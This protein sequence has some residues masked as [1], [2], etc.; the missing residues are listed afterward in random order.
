MVGM[1][2]KLTVYSLLNLSIR[3]DMRET[4]GVETL[5]RSSQ[6]FPSDGRPPWVASVRSDGCPRDTQPFPSDRWAFA[7]YLV[8]N[9]GRRS[10]EGQPSSSIARFWN[11][12]TQVAVLHC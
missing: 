8:A 1:V 10:S 7:R 5:D 2:L 3:N 12:R 9:R 11:S 6:S 4:A